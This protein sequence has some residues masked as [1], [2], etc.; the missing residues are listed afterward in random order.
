MHD[1][2]LSQRETKWGILTKLSFKDVFFKSVTC[3]GLTEM[4]K[5]KALDIISLK[6]S[7]F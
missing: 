2:A 7:T 6:S 5:L 3:N 1:D 4:R